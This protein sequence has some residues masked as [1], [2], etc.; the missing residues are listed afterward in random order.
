[1]KCMKFIKPYYKMERFRDF[2]IPTTEYCNMDRSRASHV[3]LFMWYLQLRPCGLMDKAPDFG[4]GDCRIESCH[5]RWTNFILLEG[6]VAYGWLLLAPVE[7]WWPLV[8][9]RAL[10]PPVGPFGPS[11]S[12]G[13]SVK[14]FVCI[15]LL[16]LKPPFMVILRE[17]PL[18]NINPLWIFLL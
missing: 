2:P 9:W 12:S 14:W 18:V 8:T 6:T 10:Q 16:P 1:M 17:I 5:G 11:L 13:A 4:S 3:S 15:F 7:G